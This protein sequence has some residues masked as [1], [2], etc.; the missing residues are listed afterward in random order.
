MRELSALIVSCFRDFGETTRT[1][2][3]QPKDFTTMEEESDSSGDESQFLESVAQ[4]PIVERTASELMNIW[5][6]QDK[7]TVHKLYGSRSKSTGAVPL[8]GKWF[9]NYSYSHSLGSAVLNV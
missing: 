7:K 2:T 6:Q 9:F 1:F 4:D 3:F 5:Y 8:P